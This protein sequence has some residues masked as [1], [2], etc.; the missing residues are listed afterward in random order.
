MLKEEMRRLGSLTMR[1][2]ERA[3]V[4][5]GGAL[6]V[7]RTLFSDEVTVRIR[8]HPLI[9]VEER[10]VT[11]VPEG[12]AIIATGPLTSDA[13][14]ESIGRLI[15]GEYLYFHDAAAPIVSFESIDME[16]AFFA[17]RYGRGKA[18]YINCP[19]EREEYERFH[20]E[21]IH[22]ESA[23]LHE[24]DGGFDGKTAKDG[25]KVYEGC[26][27]VEVLAK[28]GA[29][30]MRYGPLKP[31]GIKHPVTGRKYYAVVQLRAENAGGTMYNIVGFQT[32]L[33][34]GEQ[35][36]V[37]SMIP[38]LENAEFM[39]FGVM[40]RNTFINSPVLLN[41]DFSM[42]EHPD[43]YFAGQMT[44]VEGYME[45]AASGIIAG[46]AA[47]RRLLGLEPIQ[48]PKDTMT[49]ALSAY[50]SDPF[51]DGKFQPMGA[52]MGILP[53]IGVRIKDKKE[54]YGVYAK[55]AVESLQRELDRIGYNS[56]S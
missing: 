22:A 5:A 38:G 55:R 15:G 47:A 29:D 19:M 34:F 35:K 43:I 25:F 39:R 42:R 48:L 28:R 16:K 2:A 26:M 11:E 40:H 44:G 51:N 21:L 37:F 20:E 3:R 8:S 7:D 52:N 17:S 6:A 23:P 13:L 9:T 14:S 10:E 54:K 56:N 53:D 50:I 46:T 12:R 31:V 32:N 36:R 18:D 30:T 1:C 27:P 4:S 49:G 24:F 33:K 41:A 45:S